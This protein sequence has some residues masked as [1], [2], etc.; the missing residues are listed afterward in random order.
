MGTAQVDGEYIAAAST[1]ILDVT[2]RNKVGNDSHMC[3]ITDL[4]AIPTNDVSYDDYVSSPD[5]HNVIL[6]NLAEPDWTNTI[7]DASLSPIKPAEG[8]SAAP[9]AHWK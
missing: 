4:E 8:W 7:L 6:D 5:I 2:F 3:V 1:A 9:K